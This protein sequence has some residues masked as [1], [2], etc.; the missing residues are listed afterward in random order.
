MQLFSNFFSIG[1]IKSGFNCPYRVE[2]YL[3][4]ADVM[5]SRDPPC[6]VCQFIPTNNHR[7]LNMYLNPRKDQ[8]EQF[9]RRQV[10]AERRKR[11]A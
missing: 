7:R 3:K 10:P 4:G 11:Y 6:S 2:G 9:G 8:S 5:R 1:S